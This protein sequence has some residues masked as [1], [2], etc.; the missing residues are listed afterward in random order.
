M[1]RLKIIKNYHD[2]KNDLFNYSSLKLEPGFTTLVGCNG[3]GK[4]TLIKIVESY[5]RKKDIAFICFDNYEEGGREAMSKLASQELINDLSLDMISSE[6][7]RIQNNIGRFAYT[8]GTKIKKL[9]PGDKVVIVFDAIDSGFSIDGVVELKDLIDLVLND[10]KDKEV[11]ILASANG[12]ELANNERCLDVTSGKY[13]E[14]KN[15][16]E[17]KRFILETRNKKNERYELKSRIDI[18]KEMGDS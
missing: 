3:S 17:Y 6:G 1:I 8:I 13:L 16:N 11:Y 2:D 5:C 18:D 9:I 4:T 12:Y 15:Y 14:F 10:N 7:E